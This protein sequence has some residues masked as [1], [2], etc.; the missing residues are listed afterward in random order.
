M[1]LSSTKVRVLVQRQGD[2][3][4]DN[5][6]D[7]TT[8]KNLLKLLLYSSLLLVLMVVFWSHIEF[9]FGANPVP[10]I[11]LWLARLD[12]NNQYNVVG[13]CFLLR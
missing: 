10:R 3:S 2:L 7:E 5:D 1:F 6:K 12:D 9:S 11:S 4:L 13:L 8:S